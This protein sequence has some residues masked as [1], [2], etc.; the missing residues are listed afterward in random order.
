MRPVFSYLERGAMNETELQRAIKDALEGM[1][2]W[3]VRTASSGKRSSRG[4]K[5]GEP[6]IPD[7]HLVSLYPA[8]E[9]SGWLEVKLPGERLSGDQAK[10]HQRAISKGVRVSVVW[11]VEEALRTALLWGRHNPLSPQSK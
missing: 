2:V 4:V 8:T 7:L 6:G 5:T 9:R 10:W 1:G 3:V 11:T